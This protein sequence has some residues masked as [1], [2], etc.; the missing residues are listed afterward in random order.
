MWSSLFFEGA[1]P[2]EPFGA[3]VREF[4][5]KDTREARRRLTM[6]FWQD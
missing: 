4:V 6:G 2:R 3:G 5:D 1:P